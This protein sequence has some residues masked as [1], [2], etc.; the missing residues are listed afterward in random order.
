[1][2]R[3]KGSDFEMM[4]EERMLRMRIESQGKTGK[5]WNLREKKKEKEEGRKEQE[6]GTVKFEV[7]NAKIVTI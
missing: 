4:E 1:M 3:G 5:N 7:W 2:S 6:R